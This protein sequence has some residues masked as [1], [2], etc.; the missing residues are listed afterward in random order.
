MCFFLPG[1]DR[2]WCA[3]RRAASWANIVGRALSG[4]G[5]DAV[6]RKRDKSRVQTKLAP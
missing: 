3:L 1:I 4:D 6:Y 5:V 2:P